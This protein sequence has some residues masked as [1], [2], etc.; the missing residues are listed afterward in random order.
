MKGVAVGVNPPKVVDLSKVT[1]LPKREKLPDLSSIAEVE[2]L[3]ETIRLTRNGGKRYC[4]EAELLS[5]GIRFGY[6]ASTG[7]L[8]EGATDVGKFIP[9]AD[10]GLYIENML[11]F[12]FIGNKRKGDTFQKQYEKFLDW[13]GRWSKNNSHVVDVYGAWG[14]IPL[15]DATPVAKSVVPPVEEKTV[16]RGI[17]TSEEVEASLGV[18]VSAPQT[19][20]AS[21]VLPSFVEMLVASNKECLVKKTVTQ[22]CA[23]SGAQTSPSKSWR[24]VTVAGKQQV[25]SSVALL[26]GKA[27]EWNDDALEKHASWGDCVA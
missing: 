16:D 13:L 5:L 1:E 15:V 3:V 12:M 21:V 22:P 20:T 23:I 9:C 25:V 17:L 24:N 19:N 27:P 18:A 14:K 4:S 7:E 8:L 2:A 11:A 6:D 26:D 10:A